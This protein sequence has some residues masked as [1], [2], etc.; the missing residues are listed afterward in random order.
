M[1]PPANGPL[2]LLGSGPRI[3]VRSSL[4]RRLLSASATR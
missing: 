2:A 1:T 4:A 3:F